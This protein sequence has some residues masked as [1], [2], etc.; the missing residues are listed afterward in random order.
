MIDANDGKT[1]RYVFDWD[2]VGFNGAG[3]C[4]E[5]KATVAFAFLSAICWLVSALVG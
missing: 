5:M 1:N 4:G 3:G 2:N